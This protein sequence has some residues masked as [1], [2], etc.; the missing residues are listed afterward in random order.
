[1]SYDPK[2]FEQKKIFNFIVY[3]L[4]YIYKEITATTKDIATEIHLHFFKK[5][6]NPRKKILAYWDFNQR[7]SKMGDFIVFLEYLKIL[8]YETHLNQDYQRNI[9]ICFIDDNTHYNA[10]DA[11]FR[12]S[13]HFKKNINYL[14]AINENIDSVLFFCSNREFEQ[15]YLQNKKRYIRWPPTVSGTLI[16]DCRAIETFHTEHGFIPIL[17]VPAEIKTEIYQFYEKYV[18]PSLPIVINIRNNKEH[19]AKRNSGTTEIERFISHYENNKNYKFIVICDKSEIPAELRKHHNILFSKD[20]F[21]EIEYDLALIK[22]SYLSIF[23]SSGMACLAWFGNVPFI[24]HGPH[25][26]DKFTRPQEG[27]YTFFNKYQRHFDNSVSA[28]WLI[29]TFEK[30]VQDLEKDKVNNNERNR[31]R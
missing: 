14:S 29:S 6:K 21:P 26:K 28:E 11:R 23:P 18:Y 19:D 30:L 20:Y 15:F 17:D 12:K 22:T 8:R 2:K 25:G 3:I 13:Y 27:G 1:M 10:K 31:L 5:N 16:A 4:D 24:Q 9:D 7:L